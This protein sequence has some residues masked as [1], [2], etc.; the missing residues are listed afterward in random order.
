MQKISTLIVLLV[1][2]GCNTIGAGNRHT[3]SSSDLSST[4][5]YANHASSVG[6]STVLQPGDIEA[7]NATIAQGN[8]QYW[9]P[10]DEVLQQQMQMD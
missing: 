4:V 7:I 10:Q 1:L 5:S 9:A 2:A 6:Y 8:K 3:F